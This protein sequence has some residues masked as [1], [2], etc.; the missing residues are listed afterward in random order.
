MTRDGRAAARSSMC[1]LLYAHG[2]TLLRRQ[3]TQYIHTKKS[4][5]TKANE[6]AASH[7]AQRRRRPRT[8][9]VA[10]WS[11]TTPTVGDEY[12]RRL[13]RKVE[14]RNPTGAGTVL[15]RADTLTIFTPHQRE[16]P[17]RGDSERGAAHGVTDRRAGCRQD[18]KSQD[19]A[20]TALHTDRRD[21]CERKRLQRHTEAKTRARSRPQSTCTAASRPR[22]P[23]SRP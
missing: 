6:I 13:P 16:D 11:R 12:G 9:A 23:C 20:H 3:L 1:F 22:A 14:R 10:D 15:Q 19:C 17:A 2:L 7:T 18:A 8:D 4:S 21:W 5:L